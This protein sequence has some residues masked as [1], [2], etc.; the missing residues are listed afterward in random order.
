MFQIQAHSDADIG[1]LERERLEDYAVNTII[2][3]RG[4]LRLLIGILCDGVGTSAWGIQAAQDTANIIIEYMTA[5]TGQAVY[6]LLIDAVQ[7]ANRHV[8]THIPDGNSTVALIAVDLNTNVPYGHLHIASV[9]DSPIFLVRNGNLIRLNTDHTLANENILNGMPVEKAV[10]L[11]KARSLT[12]AI[13]FSESVEVDIGLYISNALD[14][15]GA[16]YQGQIGLEL[17][18]GDTIFAVSDGMV[19]LNPK[20]ERPF[21]HEE[22]FIRHALDDDVILAARSLLSYAKR[23]GPYDNIAISLIFIP[24]RQRRPALYRSPDGFSRKQSSIIAGA[25]VVIIAVV[26][27]LFFLLSRTTGERNEL[28]ETQ[29]AQSNSLASATAVQATEQAHPTGTATVTLTPTPTLTVTLT[30]TSTSTITPTATLTPTHTSTETATTTYTATATPT[31]THTSTETATI[32]ASMFPTIRPS[33]QPDEIGRRYTVSEDANTIITSNEPVTAEVTI[34][35]VLLDGGEA[36]S[37]PAVLVLFPDTRIEIDRVDNTPD[38]Q[39]IEMLLYPAGNIFIFGGQY[40]LNGIEVSLQED[41]NIRFRS[42]SECSAARYL[43]E[44]M[45]Q[46]SCY[47]SEADACILEVERGQENI[48]PAHQSLVVDIPS[49]TLITSP[50][51]ITYENAA[52]YYRAMILP[53]SQLSPECIQPYVDLDG[54]WILDT[55]DVCL[56]IPGIPTLNGCPD[57]DEDGIP[58]QEDICPNISGTN[59]NGCP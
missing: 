38:R 26:V 24:S 6:R 1:S 14:R 53:E 44:N 40:V 55:E 32:T 30:L 41:A 51:P 23:R 25:F 2:E 48:I 34:G 50:E 11:E 54:D 7:A 16:I 46:F 12:R 21:V 29:F 36:I 39:G 56:N 31:L 19:S 15:A 33:M 37:Q 59:I 28:E 4:G 17:Q 47:G 57:T 22:E 52:N 9:G 43:N 45:V 35:Y 18:A 42:H 3:T 8:F 10:Q 49:R 5:S 13:G 58:D 27:I 20:D